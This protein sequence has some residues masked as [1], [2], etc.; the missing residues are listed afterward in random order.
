MGCPV[1]WAPGVLEISGVSP[2]IATVQSALPT[3]FGL[4]RGSGFD[5]TGADVN[6]FS[7]SDRCLLIPLVILMILAHPR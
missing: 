6:P 2:V 4:S 3:L 1:C 5:D 7:G